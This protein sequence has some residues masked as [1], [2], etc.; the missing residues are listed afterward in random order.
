MRR[1]LL[2]LAALAGSAAAALGWNAH[3][4]R[5]VTYLALDA[6][7]ADM[8]AWLREA[9]ARDRIAHQSGEPDRWRGMRMAALSHENAPDHYID[10]EQLADFGLTL[11]TVPPLRNEYLKA[12]ILAKHEHPQRV[13]PYD[14]ARDE[15]RTKEWPGFLPHAIAEHYAKLAASFKT[16]RILEA[17]GEPESSPRLQQ[18]RANAEYHMG[19]LA[20]FVGDAAQPLHTTVH[21]HGWTGDNPEGYTTEYGIHSYIDGRVLEIH[22]LGYESLRGSPVAPAAVEHDDPWRDVSAYIARSFEHVEPLYRLHRDGGMEAAAGKAFIAE[23]LTDAA[24]MLAGLYSA[25]WEAGQP[26]DAD[27]ANFLR[28][29][30]GPPKDGPGAPATGGAAPAAAPK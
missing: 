5:T 28:F 1:T 16:V 24:G 29:D 13:R 2:C 9:A 8:P 7:P 25:A 6:M 10:L 21:H 23:R 4:H 26:A 17:L 15:D 30:A 20:H 14:A 3:G 18:A 19:V 11:D 22:A 12:M 27:V